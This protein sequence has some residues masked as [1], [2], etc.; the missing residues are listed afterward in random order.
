MAHK[1]FSDDEI[2]DRDDE[3]LPKSENCSI[4]PHK[5]TILSR[6]ISFPLRKQ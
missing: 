5:Y 6:D 2:Y 1:F 3:L 4:P